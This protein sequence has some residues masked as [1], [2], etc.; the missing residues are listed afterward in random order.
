MSATAAQL[1]CD[2]QQQETPHNEITYVPTAALKSAMD[3][4]RKNGSGGA[5]LEEDNSKNDC[6]E[7]D[8]VISTRTETTPNFG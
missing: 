4:D 3:E 1:T 8:K 2:S 5:T 6:D 7:E